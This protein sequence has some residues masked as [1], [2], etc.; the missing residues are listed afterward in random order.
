MSF[1]TEPLL[2]QKVDHE[3]KKKK[4]RER[5]RPFST[6]TAKK[7]LITKLFKITTYLKLHV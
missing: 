6:Q 2:T 3:T 1:E 5:K 4:N 7:T